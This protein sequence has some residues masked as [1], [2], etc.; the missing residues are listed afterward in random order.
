M[1][2]QVRVPY[3]AR[4]SVLTGPRVVDLQGGI[5]DR[6]VAGEREGASLAHSGRCM[7]GGPASEPYEPQDSPARAPSYPFAKASNA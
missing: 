7:F 5:G 6:H 3:H 2:L 1:N 4:A